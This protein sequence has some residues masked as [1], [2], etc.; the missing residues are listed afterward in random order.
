MRYRGFKCT[1]YIHFYE[2]SIKSFSYVQY[3]QQRFKINLV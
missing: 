3:N 1:S 2:N